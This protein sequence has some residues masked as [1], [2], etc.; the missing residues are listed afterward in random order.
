M[1]DHDA[2]QTTRVEVWGVTLPDEGSQQEERPR[3]RGSREST[4]E[5]A[6]PVEPGTP[7]PDTLGHAPFEV[8]VVRPRVPTD[9]SVLSS[10]TVPPPTSRSLS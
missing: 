10:L 3:C 5:F 2:P 7:P 4:S 8:E 1:E 9:T 6:H